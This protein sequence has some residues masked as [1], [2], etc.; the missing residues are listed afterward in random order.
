MEAWNDE[1]NNIKDLSALPKF[2]ITDYLE[3]TEKHVGYSV[4]SRIKDIL[5]F[6]RYFVVL[7]HFFY[8]QI[9]KYYVPLLVETGF[10]HILRAFRQIRT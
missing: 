2:E 8:D 7:L 4:G 3:K 6:F 9:K 10:V 5:E 1:D